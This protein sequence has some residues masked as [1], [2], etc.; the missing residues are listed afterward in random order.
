MDEQIEKKESVIGEHHNRGV[1]DKY[2]VGKDGKFEHITPEFYNPYFDPPKKGSKK[3]S[4]GD[5]RWVW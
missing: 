4:Y 5:A 2:A 1:F 3:R